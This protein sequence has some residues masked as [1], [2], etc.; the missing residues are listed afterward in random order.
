MRLE[1]A[2]RLIKKLK[3]ADIVLVSESGIRHTL[4]RLLQ[5]SKWHHVMLYVG[6]GRTLEVT[7]RNGAH[8]CDLLHDLTEKH[9]REIKVLRMPRLTDR[10]RKAIV[11]DA[12]K[13]FVHKKFSWLQYGKII[14]GRTLE[15]W[16]KEGNKSM[17]CKPGH[18]CNMSSI[19]CSNMVAIAYFE[20]GFSISEKYMPEYVVPRDYEEAKVLKK[21]VDR[22]FRTS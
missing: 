6:L 13:T 11:K 21:I 15:L 12:V 14:I 20:N 2:H 3:D 22:K 5:R 1:D 19:A 18:K 10:Q 16:G 17:V 8:I 7:P 9:Y 4:N